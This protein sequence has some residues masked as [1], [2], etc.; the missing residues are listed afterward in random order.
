MKEHK[1]GILFDLDGTLWDSADGVAKAWNA[2]IEKMR[3]NYH[4]TE[5]TVQGFMGKTMEAIAYALFD[6]E[7]PED[8]VKYLKECTDLEN[9]YLE[10]H[11]GVLYEGLEETLEKLH[12]EYFL[13]VVSNCQIGYIEAFMKAHKLEKYFDDFESYG[14]T[15]LEKGENIR[16]VVERNHLAGAV[17]V[18]DT[19]GDYNSTMEAGLP[20]IYAA[21]GFGQVPEGTPE[22]ASIRDLPDM[23]RRLL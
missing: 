19:M 15:L 6:R 23:A 22:I 8:A 17:Y 7:T 3:L 2:A 10:E 11:G 20:F 5:K 16:L 13:A 1:K 12:S 14:N 9:E 18:G 21:Y 4:V